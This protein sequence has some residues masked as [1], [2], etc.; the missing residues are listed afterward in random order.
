ME[1]IMVDIL[2]AKKTFQE[3]IE[4][5][6]NSEDASFKLKVVHTHHV[7]SLSREL[8]S[9]LN[10]SEEDILL[11]DQSTTT[12]ENMR[13]SKQLMD[14]R[15]IKP[16]HVVFFSNNYHIFRAGIF[17]EQVG[18]TAQG[19]GAHTARYFLPNALLREFA[20]IVM[21]N[22][23]RHMI[24]CGIISVFYLLTWLVELYIHFHQ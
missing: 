11:E 9:K 15:L 23:R 10:L 17:A 7:A 1:E 14:N 4:K 24:I 3:F 5:Y 13:F 18:L 21:M 8:A 12:L 6:N 22:K 19:L 20:A 16:Y 2:K